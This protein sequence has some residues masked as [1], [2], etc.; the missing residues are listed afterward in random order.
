MK[1]NYENLKGDD[2]MP[3]AGDSY[4][5]EIR[6]SHLDWGRHRY[7][8][9]RD[10]IPGEGYVK[11]PRRFAVLYN[12]LRGDCF[13]ATFSDGYPSFQARAAGNSE[14]GDIYAKQFQGDGDLKAFARWYAANDAQVGDFVTVTFLNSHTVNF[15]LIKD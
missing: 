7:T 9:T 8:Y 1:N 15:E 13:T 6:Q 11:I 5:V 3:N 14:A 2:Y 10:R 4:T 12:I